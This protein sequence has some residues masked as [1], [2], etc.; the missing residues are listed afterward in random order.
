MNL[1]EFYN[2]IKDVCSTSH[3]E[4]DEEDFPRQV[5]SEYATNYDYASNI[6]YTKKVSINLSHYSKVEFDE[7]EL[8]LER[9]LLEAKDVSFAKETNYDHENKVIENF[10]D[11]EI[12][13]E[14][15]L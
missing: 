6:G 2:L 10:Y 13:E 11:I 14:M 1:K 9:I 12:S 4:S 8:E 5:Y 3:Y 7:T 15:K